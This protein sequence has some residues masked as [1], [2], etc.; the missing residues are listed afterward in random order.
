MLLKVIFPTSSTSIA[1][2]DFGRVLYLDAGGTN[3]TQISKPTATLF[4]PASKYLAWNGTTDIGWVSVPAVT[5]L[6]SAY[7]AGSGSPQTITLDTT[8]DGIRIK[9]LN[10][11]LFPFEILDNG[12][13]NLLKVE[14][15]ASGGILIGPSTGGTLNINGTAGVNTGNLFING[16]QVV[17]GRQ[18][19]VTSPGATIPLLQAAVNA[20]IARLQT[21][22][23]I[24]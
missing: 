23:L 9:T 6:Q 7:S 1:V 4:S 20:I 2:G 14:N 21:H 17:T 15:T 16:T 8:R 19:T 13:N 22:G 5:T 12:S 11:V 10:A 18:P 3:L 24:A